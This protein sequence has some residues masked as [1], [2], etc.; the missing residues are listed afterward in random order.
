MIN[1]RIVKDV[2]K[3]IDLVETYSTLGRKLVQVETGIIYPSSVI[4]VI[5]G[6]DEDGK[7]YSRYTYE[8]TDEPSPESELEDA[9]NA[10]NILGVN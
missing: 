7:P 10:L 5:A 2:T 9:K 1:T 8:E 4:D 6:Y 3:K